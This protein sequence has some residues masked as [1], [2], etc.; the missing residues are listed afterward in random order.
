MKSL[1]YFYDHPAE[2]PGHYPQRF[3]KF[4]FTLVRFF[5][6]PFRLKAYGTE[7][8]KP[9]QAYLLAGNHRSYLDPV[10]ILMALRPRPARFMAKEEFFKFGPV[11]RWATWCN[12][13]PVK[14]DATDMKVVK[15]SVMMLKRGELVGIFPEG[16]RGRGMSEE[17]LMHRTPHEGVAAIARLGKADVIP[18]RL[19][20]TDR[21]SPA[22]KRFFRF[23]RITLRFGEPLSFD[24]ERYAEL[25]KENKMKT[26]TTDVMDAIYALECP[27]PG[28]VP[29][30][31]PKDGSGS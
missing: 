13:F 1:D 4:L 23:P 15:R 12:A 27:R 20:G 14:R 9:G 22:D 7:H 3:R 21:I 6:L 11:A 16:T 31:P 8:V 29:E 25:D 10:F 30:L 26:F 5:F 19:W 2:G 24:D 18:V 28:G 17:E